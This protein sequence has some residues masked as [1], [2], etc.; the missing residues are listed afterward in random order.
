MYCNTA[1]YYSTFAD[2]IYILHL[3]TS[4][5]LHFTQDSSH[6]FTSIDLDELLQRHT[7]CCDTACGRRGGRDV[8]CF[9]ALCFYDTPPVRHVADVIDM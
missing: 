5:I 8:C 3:M 1:K 7:R 6:Y 9:A 4:R 2:I